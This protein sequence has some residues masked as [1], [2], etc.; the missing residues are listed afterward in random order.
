MP[1]K[2]Q[3]KRRQ[4][5]ITATDSEWDRI[6][7]R[8]EACGMT[9]SQYVVA[10]LTVPEPDV[11][12]E[13]VDPADVLQRIEWSTRFLFEVERA[14]VLHEGSAETL[15]ALVRRTEENVARERKLG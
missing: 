7:T 11:A 1:A 13:R 10:R 14:R 15:E 4:R 8:A 9:I 5:T 6:R 2:A 3:R 12:L